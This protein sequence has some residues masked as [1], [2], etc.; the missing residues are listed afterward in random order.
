MLSC[1]KKIL[2]PNNILNFTVIWILMTYLLFLNIL[3]M[4]HFAYACKMR[5]P[6]NLVL[7]NSEYLWFYWTFCIVILDYGLELHKFSNHTLVILQKWLEIHLIIVWSLHCIL[8][9]AIFAM[10]KF[11]RK[12]VNTFIKVKLFISKTS[13]SCFQGFD[14][15]QMLLAS[16]RY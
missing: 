9:S 2:L 13:D 11:Q 14:F 1:L 3:H 6:L 8:F 16:H 5:C 7:E 15:F 10:E 4:S 12:N